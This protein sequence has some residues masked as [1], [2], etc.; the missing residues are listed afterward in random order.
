LLVA[1]DFDGTLAPLVS[2]PDQARLP[3]AT[4]DALRNLVRAKGVRVAVVSSRGLRDLARRLGMNGMWLAGGSGLETRTARGV[5][6]RYGKAA[7]AALRRELRKWCAHH[8]GAWVEVKPRSLAVHHRS[9]TPRR[10]AAFVAGVRRHTR[11]V[12]PGW[13]VIAATHACEVVPAPGRDKADVLAEWS[14]GLPRGAV[15]W[16]GDDAQ[17]EPAHAWVRRHGGVAVVVGRRPSAA[18]HRLGSPRDVGRLLSEFARAR[19]GSADAPG[20]GTRAG[21]GDR[22]RSPR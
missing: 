17:D 14:R 15:L 5:V 3:T 12:A 1:C 2:R 20:T 8:P 10:R 21:A 9:L 18:R 13:R 19:T 11:V 6:R 22:D 7:P 16:L 4:R